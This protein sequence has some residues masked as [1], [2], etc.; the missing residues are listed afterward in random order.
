MREN[1]NGAG[2]SSHL[3]VLRWAHT[4]VQRHGWGGS[5]LEFGAGKYS[6][7]FLYDLE[8]HGFPTASIEPPGE[9]RGYLEERFPGH[10]FRTRYDGDWWDVVLIDNGS[11]PETWLDERVRA[12]KQ[13]RGKCA[14]ALVHD[15]HIGPG[16]KDGLVTSFEYHG[17]FAPDERLMHTA[18]V[19][20]RVEVAGASIPGGRVYTGWDDAPGKWDDDVWPN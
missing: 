5:V 2:T 13:V 18:I 17:W 6:T 15:W 10:D 16:H 1:E 8:R 11:D 7:S 3:P 20:D 14:I 9:W 4:E 12:L 19:S